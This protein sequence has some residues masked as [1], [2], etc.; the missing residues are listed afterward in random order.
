MPDTAEKL[1]EG[2]R[3]ISPPEGIS[4]WDVDPFDEAILASPRT[5]YAELRDRGPFV[6]LDRYGCLMC[7]RFDSTEAVLRDHQGFVSSRGV[8]LSDFQFEKPWR[9]PS[10]LLEADPPE[11][12]R[13]RKVMNRA[14][15]GRVVRGLRENF[16][17]FADELIEKLVSQSEIEVVKELAEVFPTTVVPEA[18]GLKENRPDY[19]VSYGAMVFDAVGPDNAIRRRALA[20][21]PEVVPWITAACQRENLFDGHIGADIH[22]AAIGGNISSDEAAMLIRSLFS[23]GLDTTIAAISSSVWCL[24]NFPDALTRLRDNPDLAYDC[25]DEV[26]RLTSPAHTFCRTAVAETE[27]AGVRIAADSKIICSMAAAN[28][29]ERHWPDPSHFDI[30]RKP[31]SHLAFGSGLHRCVG[32]SLARAEIESV[33][34]AI[35]AR[36]RSIEI[37]EEPSWRPSNAIT[38]LAQL[39]VR[40]HN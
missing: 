22:D 7:G 8:G 39:K 2:H 27:I 23:A 31:S 17:R 28:L 21:G 26:L 3:V 19:L 29:D 14:L 9:P 10:L 15:S 11:H 13:A 1:I 12:T 37:L 32:Q 33:I 20:K 4:R 34:G 18:I 5:F 6:Y 35:A 38:S 36:V 16:R 24:A 40:L 30:D 25:V